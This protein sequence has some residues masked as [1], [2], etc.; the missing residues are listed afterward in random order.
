M[1]IKI[2]EKI[3]KNKMKLTIISLILLLALF[4]IM[5]S[6]TKMF[7]VKKITV[8]GNQEVS[9]DKLILASGIVMGESIFKLDIKNAKENLLLHPYISG[10]EIKRKLPS[11]IVI[12]IVER[13]EIATINH[14][15]SYVYIGIDGLVLDIL[16]E[17]KDNKVP[18]INGLDIEYPSIGSKI[19]YKKKDKKQSDEI[20]SF[21]EKCSKKELKAKINSIIF[22]KND[23]NFILYSGVNVAIGTLDN[24]DYKLKFLLETLKDI[25]QKKINIKNIYLNK[26]S[27]IIV[28]LVG[29]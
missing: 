2:D 25:E 4:F 26:S 23:I 17:K 29:S 3:K 8:E 5:I 22:N 10:V 9:K 11:K 16:N 15:E 20:E 18:L 21:I 14:L 19:I 6:Q 1:N 13:E 24:I 7:N 12:K 27:D 28:E